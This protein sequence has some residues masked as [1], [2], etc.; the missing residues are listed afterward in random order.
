M[1]TVLSRALEE[2]ATSP[3]EREN[4]PHGVQTVERQITHEINRIRTNP[5]TQKALLIRRSSVRARRGPQGDFTGTFVLLRGL[6]SVPYPP[7]L[8]RG[9]CHVD[10]E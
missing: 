3:H 6:R 9:A 7:E 2:S 1:D 10:V 5:H 8:P 4:Y